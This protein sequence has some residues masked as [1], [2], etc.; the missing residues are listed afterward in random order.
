MM[1]LQAADRAARVIMQ[2]YGQ[3]VPTEQKGWD[4]PV[5]QADRAADRL[6]KQMI[7]SAFP[8]DGWLSE[9]SNDDGLRL[10]KGR[11]WIVDP[12]DGTKEFLAQIPEFA[13]SIALVEQGHPVV[14][15]I[16]NPVTQDTYAATRGGGAVKNGGLI[17]VSDQEELAQATILASRSELKR[18][19][20]D[21]YQGRFQIR[22]CGGMAHKM[23]CV[24]DGRAGGQADGSFTLTPKT[25]WD[26]AA[27]DLIIREAG[28]QVVGLAGQTLLYNRPDPVING[29]IY[30]NLPITSQLLA[31]IQSG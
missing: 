7:G 25:E 23:T 14:A 12:L 1:A 10:N 6:I 13:V 21:C 28:G 16:V 3:S 2:Y 29:L 31:L 4:H 20:W 18:H 5:T 11:V 19:E 22:G 24:A 9:E 30:G 27:G 15:V 17:H 8:D 26:Y